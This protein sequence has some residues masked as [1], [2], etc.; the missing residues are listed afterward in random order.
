[1]TFRAELV[2]GSQDGFQIDLDEE[3]EVIEFVDASRTLPPVPAE[4]EEPAEPTEPLGDRL[5]RGERIPVSEFEA[6]RQAAEP[7][8]ARHPRLLYRYASTRGG[9]RRYQYAGERTP[10]RWQAVMSAL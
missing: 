10:R 5:K 6:P 4:K 8:P 2:G 9:I 7:P 3:L 1:M